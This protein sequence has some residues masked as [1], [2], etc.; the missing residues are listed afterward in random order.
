MTRVAARPE[1]HSGFTLVELLVVIAII[2][3]LVA[4]L[5][6]AVQAAREAARRMQCTNNL[7]QIALAAHNFHD[8]YKR[9]PPSHLGPMVAG[10]AAG[11][12]PT[13]G[14]GAYGQNVATLVFLLPFMEQTAVYDEIEGDLNLR[15]EHHPGMPSTQIPSSLRAKTTGYWARGRALA[16]AKTK[17]APFLCPSD[18]AYSNTLGTVAFFNLRR[19]NRTTVGFNY[20]YWPVTGA[21]G[22][23]LGR[24][25]YLSCAGAAGAGQNFTWDRYR[26][27]FTSRSQKRFADVTDG[28]SHTLFF[29]ESVGGYSATK[30][31]QFSHSW[32]GSGG[33][34]TAWGLKH[35]SEARHWNFFAAWHPGVVQFALADGAVR[36]V[37]LSADTRTNVRWWSGMTDGEVAED[38]TN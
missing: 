5:L 10:Q 28:T 22:R 7:K 1:R 29:G 38:I 6:P 23:D 15:L 18:N 12:A 37:S 19:I 14:R 32:I 9:F 21:T 30:V 31:K 3:I 34:G 11:S 36:G 25:N 33:A 2:G 20:L 27:V 26:G 8:T 4:L 13:P 17:I 24:T 16:M 35:G